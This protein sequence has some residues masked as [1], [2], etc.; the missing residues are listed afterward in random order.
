MATKKS[1]GRGLGALI[2]SNEGLSSDFE[3]NAD[4]KIINVDINKIEPDKNQPRTSFDET[5][6]K[7]L[8]QSIESVGIINPIIVKK[9]GDFY[10]IISG[11]RRWRAARLAKLKT[12]PV[13]VKTYSDMEKLEVSLIENIQRQDLNPLEEALTYKK[14]YDEFNLNQEQIAEKVGKSRTAVANS[15]RLLKLD[16]R[17]KIFL[18]EN[19]LTTGHARALLSIESNDE[20]FILADKIIDEELSVRETEELVKNFN[21]QKNEPSTRNKS[22]ANINSEVYETMAKNLN[23]ILGT[24][25]NIK[26]GKNK[27]KIEI[28]YYSEEELDR[29]FCLIN[30]ISN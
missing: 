24:K 9:N 17:I 2:N 19:K 20:Q 4:D 12:V 11:E 26:N 8:S 16:D 29:I 5:S 18:E 30:Q 7:E 27:G 15:M 25:V 28:E 10:E 14:F 3:E 23:T 6:L 1:L 13:L 21:R 22:N